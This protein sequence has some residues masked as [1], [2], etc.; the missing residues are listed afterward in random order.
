MTSVYDQAILISNLSIP[1][2]TDNHENDPDNCEY[3]EL[4]IIHGDPEGIRNPFIR[5]TGVGNDHYTTG[6]CSLENKYKEN[7]K[8]N[9]HSD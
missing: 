6:P 7:N 8:Q 4:S 9:K 2:Q 1:V 5:S 3:N